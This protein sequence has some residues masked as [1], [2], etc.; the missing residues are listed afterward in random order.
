MQSIVASPVE[1][2]PDVEAFLL[3]IGGG[4]VSAP[5]RTAFL[6]EEH[7][8]RVARLV[9][10][11]GPMYVLSVEEDRNRLSLSRAAR[12][13][14]LTRRETAVLTLIL[15]GS[16]ASEIAATLGISENTVQGYFKRLLSKTGS[17]NRV[18]MVAS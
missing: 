7:V 15:D 2:Q 18:A 10:E 3:G 9:G 14:Q 1:L 11:G 8:L 13:H 17:R 16:N 12:R 4:D 5:V 6:S